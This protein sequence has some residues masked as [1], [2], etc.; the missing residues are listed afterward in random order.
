M[1]Y[2]YGPYGEVIRASGPTNQTTNPFRFATKYWDSETD[3][4][5]FGQ[6][7]YSPSLGRFISPDPIGT[8]GG[9][10]LYAFVGNNPI[11]DVDPLGLS[12]GSLADL[13]AGSGGAA[14][15]DAGA[16]GQALGILWRVK[17][18]VDTFNTVQE[19]G[20]TM[21]DADPNNA[22]ELLMAT[23]TLGADLLGGK[24]VKRVPVIGNTGPLRPFKEAP[25]NFEVF[26][27]WTGGKGPGQ[28]FGDLRRNV[29][30]LRSIVERGQKE[31]LIAPGSKAIRPDGS[32]SYFGMEL[33][34]FTKRGY[35]LVGNKLIKRF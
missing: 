27:G 14:S 12:T 11:N 21:M 16:G 25:G 3:L 9:L 10:N 13:E 26:S 23:L 20:T 15:L 1:L 19:L 4:V 29:E 5:Y 8:D 34:W 31:I 35:E 32:L 24:L 18:A 6:R 17:N 2:E 22:D 7:Y 28:H 33:K 30:W